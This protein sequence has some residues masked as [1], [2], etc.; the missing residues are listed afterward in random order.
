M[1]STGKANAALAAAVIFLLLS[2]LA[3]YIAFDRLHASEG[4]VQHTRDVQSAL[5]QFAMSGARAGRLRAE[6]VDTGNPELLERQGEVVLQ[7]RSMM[8][9]IQHLVADNEPARD[10]WQKLEQLNEQRIA[11]MDASI[12]LKRSGKSTLDAQ[13]PF[14]RKLVETGE[15][16][17][18]LLRSMYDDEETL[19]ARRQAR[20]RRTSSTTTVVLATSLFLALILFL[21]HHRLLTDEVIARTRADTAQKTLSARLLTLQDEERRRFARELHDSVGQ[22]LAA[23]KMGISMLQDRLPGD[24]TVEDC[25]KMLDDSIAE[26]RTI[27]HLLHPPLLDEA[28]LRSACRWFVEGFGKRSGIE[29]N[30]DLGDETTRLAQATELVLF[31]VLQESLTNVHRHS[32]ATRADVSMR[33]LAGQLELRVRDNGKGMPMNTVQGFS[34]HEDGAGRGVGLAGMKERVREIGG[35][36]EIHSNG[37]GTEIA[38]RVP[39]RNRMA[40]P[41]SVLRPGREVQR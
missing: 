2:S 27:S 25:L 34:N 4:W 14:S 8:G 24:T 21:I 3:A 12:D 23:I 11:L 5:S 18:R 29:V 28:G 10:N 15:Q 41:A 38:V 40:E 30:L 1:S 37:S 26:T 6:Y 35:R 31:R 33:T 16:T 9:V 7:L 13:A 32:G 22:H 19:L 36:L 39:V 17:D 20:V